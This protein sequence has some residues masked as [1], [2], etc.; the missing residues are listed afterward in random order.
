MRHSLSGLLLLLAGA[1][2]AQQPAARNT[3]ATT[4]FKAESRLVAIDVIATDKHGKPVTDLTMQD[5]QILQDEKQQ[6]IKLF[7]R[8]TKSA[9]ARMPVRSQLHLMP[10]VVTNVPE[11]P[12]QKPVNI[13]LLD[14][15]NSSFSSQVRA[16]QVAKAALKTAP[17]GE[18]F[19]LYVISHSRMQLVMDVTTDRLAMARMINNQL[20]EVPFGGSASTSSIA[21][22]AT[23]SMQS[24]ALQQTSFNLEAQGQ[25]NLA[26]NCF[27]E[28]KALRILAN[29]LRG[30][31]GRK[32]LIWLSDS[33]AYNP[34]S[35]SS[36]CG[37]D[38]GRTTELFTI[39]QVAIYPIDTKGLITVPSISSSAFMS[40]SAGSAS[41]ASSPFINL[42]SSLPQTGSRPPSPNPYD[43]ASNNTYKLQW[44]AILRSAE[45]NRMELGRVASNT[46]AV[47]TIAAATG[48]K[49]YVNTNNIEGALKDSFDDG[50]SYYTLGFYPKGELANP[51]HHLNITVNRPGIDLRYRKNYVLRDYG[52]MD[53]RERAQ[54]FGLALE[55]NSPLTT[56]LFFIAEPK[57][58]DAN[59]EIRFAVDAQKLLF[60]TDKDGKQSAKVDFVVVAYDKD[61]TPLKTAYK[62][63]ESSLSEDGYRKVLQNGFPGD[64]TIALLPGQYSVRLGVRDSRTGA[65]GTATASVS[66]H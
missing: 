34:L 1:S 43:S 51:Q 50:T 7:D 46:V 31:P 60:E 15:Q 37:I 61:G 20:P 25:D 2:F 5:F 57:Q 64:L 27:R 16:K 39:S 40:E 44:Q 48:G 21:L 36:A 13:I 52:K 11:S 45:Q 26:S 12:W 55:L 28:G 66:M 65:L 30:I 23:A 54:D 63:V 33:F 42:S 49:G 53:D 22:D 24:L 35:S 3:D 41:A 29:R 4:T 62:S 17:A 59:V 58:R 10:G 38:S 32:K 14:L 56:E 8:I 6:T 19:A 18:S 9:P 47:R